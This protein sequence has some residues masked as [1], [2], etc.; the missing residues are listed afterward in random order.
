MRTEKVEDTINIAI[1]ASGEGT[2]AENIIQYFENYLDVDVSCLI[3]NKEDAGVLKRIRR[4]KVPTY[5][6]GIYKEID[7]I[8]TEHKIHYIVLAGY[9]DKIPPNF[10]KKYKWKIINIHPSLLPKHGGKGMYGDNVHKSV[11]ESG[12]D[13]TGITI[14]FVDEHYDNGLII[15]QQKVK[16]LKEDTVEDIKSKVQ[17]LE[18]KYLPLIVEKTIKNTYEK[19]YVKN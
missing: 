2:N 12:D 1:M 10:C 8:L 7:K 18:H 15:F 14:H 4:Y 11:K 5:T 13:E 16:V 17:I 19:L 6:T 3:S 9:L